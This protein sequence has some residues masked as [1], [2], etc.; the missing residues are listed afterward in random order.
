VLEAIKPDDQPTADA[1][2]AVQIDRVV[3]ASGNLGVCGEQFWLGTHRAGDTVTLWIDTTTVHLAVNGVHLKTLPSRMT[4]SDLARLRATGGRPAGPPPTTAAAPTRPIEIHRTVNPAGC[5][6]IAGHQINV[7]THHGRR[8]ITLH[9]DDQLAHVIVDHTR[10]R[11]LPLRLTSAQRSRLRTAQFP[12]ATPSPSAV[13][14]GHNGGSPP[15]A[16][17]RSS[18]N[19]S[20][21][22]SATP[23]AWSPSRSTRQCYASTTNAA[24]H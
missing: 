12:Q 11:T 15:A 7:G 19:A 20:P 23:A 17:P 9:L 24:T 18:A 16:S 3:P 22:G 5:V 8:R 1:A 6:S 14:P 13:P 10:T 2:T 4:T 21:S